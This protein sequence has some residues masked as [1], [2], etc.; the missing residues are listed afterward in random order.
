MFGREAITLGISPHSNYMFYLQNVVIVD[1]AVSMS[2]YVYSDLHYRDCV[3]AV[4]C[5]VGLK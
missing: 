5:F 3:S 1:V 4:L 2:K